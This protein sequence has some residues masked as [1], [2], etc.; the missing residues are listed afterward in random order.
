ML[1]W[2]KGKCYLKM[3]GLLSQVKPTAIMGIGKELFHLRGG[4][5]VVGGITTQLKQSRYFYYV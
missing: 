2:P 4:R 1:T 5:V 3:C